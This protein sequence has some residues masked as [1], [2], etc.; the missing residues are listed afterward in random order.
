MDI[1]FPRRE[2]GAR[3]VG[4]PLNHLLLVRTTLMATDSEAGLSFKIFRN[5]QAAIMAL[6]YVCFCFLVHLFFVSVALFGGRLEYLTCGISQHKIKTQKSFQGFRI[7]YTQISSAPEITVRKCNWIQ[8]RN[9]AF[10]LLVFY[11]SI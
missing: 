11:M 7:I 1:Y 2:S 6:R 3:S 9:S 4:W 8:A 5:I 10:G